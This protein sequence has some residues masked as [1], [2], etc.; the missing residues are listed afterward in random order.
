[1]S[2]PYEMTPHEH[3]RAAEVAAREAED[4]SFVATETW[5][6]MQ[7]VLANAHATMAQAQMTGQM[8]A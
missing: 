3:I 5:R 8:R 7:A 6:L 4:Q 2:N 1:M